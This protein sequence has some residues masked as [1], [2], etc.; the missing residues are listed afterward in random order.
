MTSLPKITVNQCFV[1][2]YVKDTSKMAVKVVFGII[3][4]LETI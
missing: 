2:M 4:S 3:Y 1:L